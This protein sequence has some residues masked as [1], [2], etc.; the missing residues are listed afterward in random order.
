MK[1]TWALCL[2]FISLNA[3]SQ[4]LALKR[5]EESPRHHEWVSYPSANKTMHAFVVYPEKSKSTPAVI[6]IHEN[7]GLTDWV[8]GMADQIAEA[9]YLAIAPDLLSSFDSEH[10]KTSD[11]K[12]SDDARTALYQLDSLQV[13]KDL[14]ATLEYVSKDKACNGNIVVMGFCWG[15]SQSFRFACHNPSTKANMVFY[16]S[17]PSDLSAIK[18]IQAPV[19]GFYGENDQRINAGIEPAQKLMQLAGKKYEPVI[20]QG[21]GHA[22]MR[23]G[24]DPEANE[25]VKKA[26]SDSWTRLKSILNEL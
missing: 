7:R 4:D 1:K 13:L 23:A 25:A 24:E 8:R 2:A 19:Y 9:G 26:V 5:L 22:Y 11:F 21:A 16:G 14:D 10:K 3:L 17:A 20:Y 15:G 18:K 12:N 6:I